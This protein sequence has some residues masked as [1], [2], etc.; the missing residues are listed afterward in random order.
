MAALNEWQMQLGSSGTLLG[1]G[2]SYQIESAEGF[3]RTVRADDF[4]RPAAGGDIIGLDRA[5]SR[6]VTLTL[7]VKGNGSPSTALSLYDALAASWNSHRT[8]ENGVGTV[9]F[10]FRLPGRDSQVLLAGRPRDIDFDASTLRY[11]WVRAVARYFCP[12][13]RIFSDAERVVTLTYG[14]ANQT[15]PNAGNH[16][17]PVTWDVEG[18]ATNPALIR[19]EAARFDL[20]AT[21]A[22]GAFWRVRTD[23]H[24]VTRSTDSASMYSSF[25]GTWLE[26]P[27]GG[28]L[29]RSTATSP[30]A[31]KGIIARYR[32]T[33]L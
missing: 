20:T 11:G 14:A 5:A 4:E 26:V 2:T 6:T 12:D 23:P 27:P 15:L 17:A 24:T 3:G 21:V 10:R 1:P 9:D 13:A 31:G 16:P 28:A 30:T 32:D 33:W 22:S 25:A 29:F 8:V 18:A 7:V 19:S